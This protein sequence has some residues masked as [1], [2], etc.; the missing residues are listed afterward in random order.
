MHVTPEETTVV[1]PPWTLPPQP[2][3]QDAQPALSQTCIK[4]YRMLSGACAKNCGA[5]RAFVR[6]S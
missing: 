5:V 4:V 2:E 1:I 6:C 3:L